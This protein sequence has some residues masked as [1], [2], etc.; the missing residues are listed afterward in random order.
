MNDFDDDSAKTI[1]TDLSEGRLSRRD[2]IRRSAALGVSLP[3]ISVVLAALQVGQVQ[4][5]QTPKSGGTLREGYDHDFSRMDPIN[6]SFYDPGFFALYEAIITRDADRQW[7]SELAESWEQAADGLSWTF[8][9]R[10]GLKFHSGAPLDAQAIADVFNAIVNPESGSPQGAQWAPV[11]ESIAVDPTT[12][13]I[14]VKH[15]FA[16]LPNVIST[17]YSRIVNMATRA[18]LGADYGKQEI[19]GSGPF[20]FV[21]WVPGDHVSVKRWDE[22]PGSIIPFIANKG[23]AY[24]DGIQWSY[25]SETA[26]RGLAIQ[27]KELDTLK[28][29][30]FQDI[31]R[32]VADPSLVVTEVGEQALWYMGV[33]FERFDFGD[34]R[35][36]QAIAHALDRQTIVDRLVFGHGKVA[37]G[38]IPKSSPDY[39]SG[40]EAYN[41]YDVEKAK[42]LLSEAGWTAGAD[43]ILEKDGKRFAFELLTSTDSFERQLAA[44]IQ[45]ML[46]AI[47]LEVTNKAVDTA[48]KFDLLGKDNDAFLFN[49]AWPNCYDV[50]IV[51]SASASIPFPNWQRANLPDLD[52]AHAAYQNAA[53][54]DELQAASSQGQL[55]G[56][57]QLPI[58][59]IFNPST[60]WVAQSYVKNYLP[61]SWNLYP[62]YNDIW[63]D[64]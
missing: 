3:A 45:E 16:N 6:T 1:V 2:F 53:S 51:I 39:D 26:T 50:Y 13:Q 23:P 22:Y 42:S 25:V 52:A 9:I 54:A 48:T 59:P 28:G 61:I 46:R 32:L 17:G 55:V 60:A 35:V 36:R 56:A 18:K 5:Q 40:V 7:V 63:L 12:L 15:S 57:Q 41:G 64:K 19:D 58:I 29:P 30:A 37:Y 4:A 34:I 8:K 43:G 20:T 31:E 14:K 11:S 47:G 24:L 49:Y 44:V 27:N 21:E 62:Y 33:N 10:P 38:P